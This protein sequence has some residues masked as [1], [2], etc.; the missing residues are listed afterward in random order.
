MTHK[1]NGQRTIHK[2]SSKPERNKR[3]REKKERG[4]IISF[5]YCSNQI[6]GS[7]NSERNREKRKKSKNRILG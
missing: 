2:G 6:K 4:V 7:L 5:T 1:K 3:P